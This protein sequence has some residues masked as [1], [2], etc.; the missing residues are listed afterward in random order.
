M[1]APVPATR[2]PLGLWTATALVV[3]NIIGSGLFLLPSTLAAY[4]AAALLGWAIS[5][6]G[7]L[8]LALVFAR[9]GRRHPLRGGPYAFA[10]LAFGPAAGFGVAWSYWIATWCGN[11]AIAVGFTG[12]FGALVPVATST[13]LHSAATAI[14]A[15]W[16]CTLINIAGVRSAGIVQL[17]TT[18]L[19]LL[20]LLAIAIVGIAFVQPAELG[21]FN[22]SG[23]NPWSVAIT[24]AALTLWAFLGLESATIPASEVA[25]P[26]RT[27]PRATLIGTT[28]AALATL[29]ACM[30][31]VAL[32][33]AD[34]LAHSNAPFAD[35]ATKL[36][37]AGAGLLFAGAAAI[38][39]F[40]ALN[41]WVLMQGQVPLAAADDGLFPS[42]FARRDANGTPVAGLVAGS[43]LATL[44]LVA[45]YQQSLVGLFTFSIL[46]ST[47]ATLVP[48]LVCSAADLRLAGKGEGGPRERALA[49][50]ALIFSAAALIGTGVEALAWGVVLL[51]AGWPVYA[52][53]RRRAPQR[54][55]N[56]PATPG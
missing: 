3:G 33:P 12:N 43:V 35:A 11:A 21:P 8:A 16:I 51:A 9:L 24:T 47:A 55:V 13:P 50:F 32:L 34:T 28:I 56:R 25:D 7:A 20:P 1:T 38:A 37:G 44:L 53:Q 5:I 48:Y 4:G 42:M 10:H 54:P 22:R 30:A 29:S 23:G 14:A 19:K 41:G 52:W 2:A 46:V 31:V 27:V 49:V 40:G 17:V 18:V 15:L 36:W 6:T 26:E 39:C 45:N